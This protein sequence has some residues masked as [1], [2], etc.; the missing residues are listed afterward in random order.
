LADDQDIF[1][2]LEDGP[3]SGKL[4]P[5]VA[6][7]QRQID[8]AG[9]DPE[10]EKIMPRP[11]PVVSTGSAINRGFAA[12]V[13]PASGGIL[14]GAGAGAIGGA[15]L[16]PWGAVGGALA[17]G[18]AGGL[19][20]GQAQAY[21]VSKMP[22][23]WQ[24]AIG[25][26]DR[27]QRLAQEQHPYASFLGGLA[28]FALTMSP[29]GG[30]ARAIPPNATNLERL[31]ANP[32]TARLFSGAIMG[33]VET[34][35]E[36]QEG[37]SP[38]W[39]KVGIAT[40]FGT[41]FTHPTYLGA[42]L[43][44]A[45][46]RA[47]EALYELR[48]LPK[49]TP[50][51]APEIARKTY[52]EGYA[53]FQSEEGLPRG[54]ESETGLE[55]Q[56]KER[57][58]PQTLADASDLGE[59]WHP[60]EQPEQPEKRMPFQDE[61]THP[62]GED[63]DTGFEGRFRDWSEPP[64]LAEAD[65]LGVFGK[66]TEETFNGEYDRNDE[67]KRQAFEAEAAHMPPPVNP[68]DVE[69]RRIAPDVF[70]AYDT[71][72]ARR[73]VFRE[74]MR[75]AQAPSINEHLE[76]ERQIED[77]KARLPKEGEYPGGRD[78]RR[79]R[80]EIRTLEARRDQM[81]AQ[82]N[83]FRAGEGSEN[84]ETAAIRAA[85]IKADEE[86]RD[87][88]RE[89]ARARRMAADKLVVPTR[90]APEVEE[91][92]PLIPPTPAAVEARPPE[93]TAPSATAPSVA[94]PPPIFEPM[95]PSATAAEPPTPVT[96]VAATETPAPAAAS[97]EPP[98][99]PRS[100]QEQHDSIVADTKAK[101]IAAGRPAE[102]AEATA[103]LRA[104]Y[105][106]RLAARFKGKLGSAEDIYR[107]RAADIA[108][109]RE[110]RGPGLRQSTEQPLKIVNTR[111][112][113]DAALREAW[114]VHGRTLDI[115]D[116]PD[117]TW[118]KAVT[119][120]NKEHGASIDPDNYRF[121]SE[122]EFERAFEAEH[123]EGKTAP[124]PGAAKANEYF[125]DSD[126]LEHTVY[127]PG[128]Q[129]DGWD[130]KGNPISG[131]EDL[132]QGVNAKIQWPKGINERAIIKV[133]AKADASSVPHE[134]AHEWLVDMMR[135]ARHPEAP[136][137]MRADAAVIERWL[138]VSRDVLTSADRKTRFSK[139]GVK[140]QEKFARGFEQYL[141][142]GHA[143]STSLARVFEQFKH[144]MLN[145]YKTL[146]G[147]GAPIDDDIR[148]VFDRMLADSSEHIT[149]GSERAGGPQLHEIHE[150]DA[151]EVEA[152]HADAAA[153][154]IK[155]ERERAAAE[156]PEDIAYDIAKAVQAVEAEAAERTGSRPDAGGSAEPGDGGRGKM[157]SGVEASGSEPGRGGVG[158]SAVEKR[159][160]G[161][162]S[163]AESSGVGRG[164]QRSEVGDSGRSGPSPL[165]PRSKEP[166][167]T[168]STF[169]VG[170]NNN[171]RVENITSHEQLMAAINEAVERNAT[172][173]GD[174]A[175]TMGEA[176][177]TA[178]AIGADPKF[179]TPEGLARS[180]GGVK[181]LVS[182][183]IALR[184]A[185]VE[186]AERYKNAAAQAA[187][188]GSDEA[189]VAYGLERER[190]KMI[191]GVLSSVTSEVGRGLGMGFRNLETW[192][193][194]KS[195]AE[196][197]KVLTGTSLYQ[198]KM[199]AKLAKNFDST[200][201]LARWA[202]D[203]EKRSFGRML[204]EYFVNN[205]ISGLP[206]HITYV[207]GG[208]VLLASKM[209]PETLA[210]AALGRV[211]EAMGREGD[212]VYAGEAWAQ[213]REWRR[214]QPKAFQA[215]IEAMRSGRTTAMPGEEQILSKL[216]EGDPEASV[217]GTLIGDTQTKIAEARDAAREKLKADRVA[218]RAAG[219]EPPLKDTEAAKAEEEHIL[220]DLVEK[221]P[222]VSKLSK[223]LGSTDVSWH[224][225]QADLFGLIRGIAD[226]I[227]AN[228]GLALSGGDAS[229]PALSLQFSHAGQIPDLNIKGVTVPVGSLWR[230]PSRNVAMLHSYQRTL[231]Y[232]TEINAI[233]YRMATK[234][235][236]AGKIK[237]DEAF[238]DRVNS[239]RQN[240]TEEM[241]ESARG[242]A[243]N[244]TLMDHGGVFVQR[245]SKLMD[246]APHLPGFGETPILR[247]ISPFVK[248]AANIM[249]R[250]LIE[251]SPVGLLS[252]SMRDEL[253]GKN[254]TVRADIAAGR[255]LVGT[256]YAI[257]FGS[258]AALGYVNGS[259]PAD[260]GR[261]AIWEAAGNRKHS[262]RIGDTWL[263]LHRLG[264]LGFL[265][266]VSADMYDVGHLA[267]EGEGW[268]AAFELIHGL[269][270]NMLDESFMR[271]P[272]ELLSAIEHPQEEG[273]R[274]LQNFT[275]NFLPMSVGVG[276]IAR[277]GDPYNRM[278][279]D[280]T[281]AL[282]A[283]IP[284]LSET[285]QPRVDIF[286]NAIPNLPA[287]GSRYLSAL[288]E[289]KMSNDPVV[290]A[291]DKAGVSIAPA[292]QFVRGIKLTDEQFFQFAS[293]AGRMTKMRLN[294]WVGS[295][296]WQAMDDE[297][298]RRMVAEIVQQCRN[299]A[300]E[301][302]MARY[303]DI[304]G[305]ATQL[306]LDRYKQEKL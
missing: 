21:A 133:F 90:E 101:L 105:Y 99:A 263:D 117:R 171:V 251:R 12:S 222:L 187:E 207:F 230:L 197:A 97:V 223:T 284:G 215:A 26:S 119:A 135:N 38:D 301:L 65:S 200:A 157:E 100:V 151:R 262:V 76:L 92:K 239:L 94:E 132:R 152:P 49:Q 302:L 142:E 71:A 108:K 149:I 270:Q 16:G 53:P 87:I 103:R 11:D 306:R 63:I 93:P 243:N 10:L 244:M 6:M 181:N 144:W 137:D 27:Q 120:W 173:S 116:L 84:A 115:D 140:A 293:T 24:E 69:A 55:E 220:R 183:V 106:V 191:S 88:G 58:E 89:V 4:P 80:A 238:S 123:L 254:G 158:E 131:E 202:R 23:D 81:E 9:A 167:E 107:A 203:S 214:S 260:P 283:K 20:A 62:F 281:S 225:V 185:V 169:N 136:A 48:P 15:A 2:L 74:E 199:E 217:F 264:P 28:P 250:S 273:Q 156:P 190:L 282:K 276:Y 232:S 118:R 198:L 13:L 287:L 161:N 34:A 286:G 242:N 298:K 110:A 278:T 233:A 72:L 14:A 249:D 299:S 75:R 46:A 130:D 211:R 59:F 209:G 272:A 177:D 269:T 172:P 129:L 304:A 47:G 37:R 125:A 206:T 292:R 85:L 277:A 265:L 40:G 285:L 182:K 44:G 68:L 148:S 261:R 91:A 205:L 212:R 36:F 178:A 112:E 143:P 193:S 196:Q 114:A 237:T 95:T 195:A 128:E 154:R 18:L 235:R 184:Q 216:Y 146:K 1:S 96:P 255:M 113:Q 268:A 300:R 296:D 224:E 271:G 121:G 70:D 98:R 31:M 240:P 295:P 32:M 208:Q 33:G 45:G 79:L 294:E 290:Q 159:P 210:A 51:P 192:K 219:A 124:Y 64:T 138:G 127:R 291:L 41:I 194:A 258:L 179:V 54:F 166:V 247:F 176:F 73:N 236:L 229:A 289:S 139:E 288:Y 267:K 259:G 134:L 8:D 213:L 66:V 163:S 52:P 147:L 180:L 234:E 168:G 274:Y 122:P 279:R 175:L 30:A 109:A 257:G 102:D 189:A 42:A 204:L 248:I 56:N 228:G 19:A 245:L 126:K 77:L 253:S 29:F 35:Q 5:P 160:S 266:G 221:D 153:A 256:A 275:S 67:V 174:K 162:G 164:G 227:R 188:S 141:R 305:R 170:R 111:A 17:G 60:P 78:N 83:A 150:A 86:L 43:E 3:D 303:P 104:A 7:P 246:I 231:T 297:T 22:E 252:K 155:A 165:A 201:K 50:W 25:M 226:S 186:Q 57:S 145:I 280:F 39:V 218:A 61:E 241:M 82:R